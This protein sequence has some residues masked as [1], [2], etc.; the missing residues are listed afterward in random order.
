MNHTGAPGAGRLAPRLYQ[1][2]FDILS[3]QIGDGAV[4]SGTKLTESAVAAQ[5]GI[6]RAPARRALEELEKAG[7]VTKS[8]GRGYAVTG[9]GPGYSSAR[10]GPAEK[11]VQLSSLSTWEQIYAQVEKQII[12]RISFASWRLNEAELA[13]HY[14]VSR[15]VA[16]DVVAR[17]QQRG[18]V[19]KDERSRWYAPA[20]SPE[21]VGELYELRAILE[22]IALTKAAP[23]VPRDLFARMRRHLLEAIAHAENVEGATLDRLEEEMHVELL[24]FCGNRALM[25]AIT[26]PQSLLIAHRFLYRWTPRLFASEPFLPEHLKILEH[27]ETGDVGQ[28]ARALE[29]HL[30]G[31]KARALARVDV[32][33]REFQ[34]EGLPYLDRL[35]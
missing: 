8:A 24:S 34:P 12:G 27:L 25:Q 22:P 16:R 6:S 3:A 7:L 15:T 1:R 2:A 19:L 31:S 20:L 28:A 9:S 26:M 33:R 13:R 18:L 30:M 21:H 35:A 29:A 11:E 4:Q 14:N 17:L 32:I 5:F 10:R 23:R